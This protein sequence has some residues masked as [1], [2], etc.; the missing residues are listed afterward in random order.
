MS[1]LQ[2][3]D[4]TVWLHINYRTWQGKKTLTRG[5]INKYSNSELPPED[6]ITPGSKAIADPSKLKTINSLGKKIH[7]ECEKVALKAFGAYGT[8]AEASIKLLAKLEAL[9]FEHTKLVKDFLDNYESSTEDW[10]NEHPKFGD[11]LRGSMLTRAEIENRFVFEVQAYKISAGGD[12][13]LMTDGLE[14]EQSGLL[15][16]LLHEI[17]KAATKAQGYIENKDVIT[18]RALSPIK[19]IYSKLETL[20]YID[21]NVVVLMN[22]VKDVLDAMPKSGTIQGS[23]LSSISGLVHLLSSS[24]RMLAFTESAP[25]D[26]VVISST[27]EDEAQHQTSDDLNDDEAVTVPEV[28]LASLP[29]PQTNSAFTGVNF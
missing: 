13:T 9:K 7:R 4:Q 28:A 29:Q 21:A 12:N 6:L 1:N 22:R 16:T 20:S 26:N 10:I 8:S 11:W 19:G 14:K 18:Q 27:I 17:E 23:D 5:E 2:T 15:G 25:T 3:L 24:Q